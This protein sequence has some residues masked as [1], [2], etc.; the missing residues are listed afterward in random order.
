M[1]DHDYAQLD[2]FDDALC[3]WACHQCWNM[4]QRNQ[5]F[6]TFCCSPRLFF[7]TCVMQFP[8][9]LAFHYLQRRSGL[10]R[11]SH[12]LWSLLWLVVTYIHRLLSSHQNPGSVA[13]VLLTS[14][15][16]TEFVSLPAGTI[17]GGKCCGLLELGSWA[18][19][20]PT[21]NSPRLLGTAEWSNFRS[22][23]LGHCSYKCDA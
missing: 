2:P 11:I 8:R 7:Y 6:V 16:L 5:H 19:C 14:L 4:I 22:V 9:L 12:G 17:V 3:E 23:G 21:F 18:S 20:W 1:A 15:N 10:L 13:F